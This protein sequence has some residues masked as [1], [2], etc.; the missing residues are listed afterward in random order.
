MGGVVLLP[1]LV[2]GTLLFA[3]WSSPWLWMTLWIVITFGCIGG[4][5]DYQ[6]VIHQNARGL[7]G[8]WKLFWQFCAVSMIWVA[9]R[10]HPDLSVDPGLFWPQGSHIAIPLDHLSYGL[11]TYLVII[12]SSNAV[13]LTDGL[14]GLAIVPVMIAIGVLGFIGYISGDLSLSLHWGIPYIPGAQALTVFS[15]AVVGIGCGFLWFNAQPA[16]IF[17]GDMAALALGGGMGV[18]AM[19]LHQEILLLLIGGLFVIEALSVMVQVT[20]FKMTKGRRIFKMAPLHHHF[21]CS[22]WSAQQVT[23]RAWIL[24]AWLAIFGLA[25]IGR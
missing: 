8:R 24:S 15:A 14:D 3:D 2:I 17:M 7:P 12:G 11:L 9:F 25:C 13:N 20:Y 5:D 22:G 1:V 21:E 10:W 6:K 18:M 4:W 23:V 19:A 16:Q